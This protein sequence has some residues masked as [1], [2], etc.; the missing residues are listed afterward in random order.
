[1]HGCTESVL[2]VAFYIL[3]TSKLTWVRTETG[4]QQPARWCRENRISGY[5]L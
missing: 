1:V 4:Y 3:L 5:L 2:I